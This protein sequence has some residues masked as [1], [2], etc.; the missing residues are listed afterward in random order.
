MI[1]TDTS[2]IIDYLRAPESRLVKIIR[3]HGAAICGPTI[4]E[5]YA[6]AR[7][8]A[9]FKKYDQALSLFSIVPI[10]KKI[11]PALGRNLA[12]LGSKGITFP[13]PDALVATVAIENDLEIWQHD[14][15]FPDI[16]KV[17][18]TLKFFH[19]PP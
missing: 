18:P 14:R 17:I 9:D 10:P 19:E 5:V 11:W 6:G 8:P 2:I 4:A 12:L 3:G 15:H 13:F 16:Q 1:L 7:T